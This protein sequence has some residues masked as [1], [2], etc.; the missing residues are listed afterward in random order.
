MH[1]NILYASLLRVPAVLVARQAGHAAVC[2]SLQWLWLGVVAHR[3]PASHPV[4]ALVGIAKS[5]VPCTPA[6]LLEQGNCLCERQT[7][8][9]WAWQA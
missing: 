3:Q 2:M 4:W 6:F 7:T 1:L 5:G 9:C 8:S